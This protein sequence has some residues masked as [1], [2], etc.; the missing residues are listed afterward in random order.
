LTADGA[1]RCAPAVTDRDFVA[2]LRP[3][4]PAWRG[5]GDFFVA[6]V[7]AAFLLAALPAAFFAVVLRAAAFGLLAVFFVRDVVAAELFFA[8]AGFRA[9]LALVEDFLA[10]IRASTAQQGRSSEGA[11][12]LTD[13]AP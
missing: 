10:G 7:A 2:G 4:L 6:G 3:R 1:A 5:A 13:R 12:I 11:I 9:F 8:T